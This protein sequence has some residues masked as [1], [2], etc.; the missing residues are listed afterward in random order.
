[1]TL[2]SDVEAALIA[3]GEAYRALERK[4]LS[5][6]AALDAEMADHQDD[7]RP[8]ARLLA[9][10]L[11]PW[12]RAE[13]PDHDEALAYLDNVEARSSEEADSAPPPLGVSDNL[14]RYF[15][16]RVTKLMALHLLLCSDWRQWRVLTALLYLRRHRDHD[17]TAAL[18]RFVAEAPFGRWR[19]EAATT[20]RALGDPAW[21][22]KARAERARLVAMDA[23][24]PTEL[25]ELA[26]RA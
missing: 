13:A 4:L 8:I 1:M 6:G 19:E 15:E 25:D 20:V 22:D 9:Q 14:T 21:R 12:A 11:L 10:V 16:G 23:G 24:V 26:D 7:P 2:S 3:R 18:L 5:R 17:T